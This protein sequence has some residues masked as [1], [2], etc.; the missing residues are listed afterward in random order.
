VP[1]PG[2]G[3]AVL[4]I[5]LLV[6]IL[7]GLIMVAGYFLRG[8]GKPGG[9]GAVPHFGPPTT[10]VEPPADPIPPQEFARLLDEAEK[11]AVDN[12]VEWARRMAQTT[13]TPEQVERI[14]KSSNGAQDQI[15]RVSRVLDPM[16]KSDQRP[17]RIAA[18]AALKTWGTRDN[19]ASIKSR[20]G[21][22]LE[23]DEVNKAGVAALGRIRDQASIKAIADLLP[24]DWALAR[25]DV[26]ATLKSIGPDAEE[27]VIPHLNV[28][29]GFPV[30][31]QRKAAA[32]VLQVIGTA[33]SIP[34]LELMARSDN[35]WVKQ[36]A[37]KALAAIRARL[38]KDNK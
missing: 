23:P 16:I 6:P 15:T 36:E 5:A 31:N 34:E 19:V 35:T 12:R 17:V 24:N 9:L 14:Q 22:P 2:G 3:S 21:V 7:A 33:K 10:P 37:D 38:P 13:P 32:Q 27:A 28:S 1:A 26:A 11:T 29:G 8:S 20:L 25:Y 18:A 30:Q 4:W